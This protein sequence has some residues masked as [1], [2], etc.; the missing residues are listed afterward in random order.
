MDYLKTYNSNYNKAYRIGESL[1][2]HKLIQFNKESLSY[3]RALN[4]TIELFENFEKKYSIK[5]EVRLIELKNI[6]KNSLG[7][8]SKNSIELTLKNEVKKRF[9]K[10]SLDTINVNYTFDI[11]IREYD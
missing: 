2:K 1:I 9:S 6:Y 4:L 7:N 10:L 11:F 5:K 3:T 8:Y